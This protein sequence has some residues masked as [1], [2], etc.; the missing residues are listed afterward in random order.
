MTAPRAQRPPAKKTS[1]RSKR[2]KKVPTEPSTWFEQRKL[3]VTNRVQSFLARR[4]HRSFRLTRRRDYR[5]SLTIDGLVPFTYY[6]HKTLWK[7]KAVF[8]WLMAAY[9]VLTALLVTILSQ[10]NYVSLRDTV[11]GATSE[12]SEG[13]WGV[14]GN[15][16]LV[17]FSLFSNAT[18]GAPDT[19]QQ[20]YTI[21]I[22]LMVWLTTVWLLRNI[23]AGNKV[24]VRDGIYNAGAPI[25][26]TFLVLAVL[27]IQLLPLALG[28]IATTVALQT[29]F[30]EY[31]AAAMVMGGVTLLLG[32]LSLYWIT[33]TFMALV[34]VTLP[35]MYPLRALSIAGDM[36]VGRRLRILLRIFWALAVLLAAWFV[37]MVPLI[38]F[39]TWLKD[40]VPAIE[41]IPL[42]PVILVAL[43]AM[44]IVWFASY[45]YLLYRKVVD[46]DA[47][48]A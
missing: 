9:A 39:D 21:L 40:T 8:F 30:F 13:N 25:I 3:A 47:L 43:S 2:T 44:T 1:E 32:L 26:S 36:V 7:H 22:I 46:D 14:V 17:L 23:L 27:I 29:G 28:I 41:W 33:A 34:V 5:R 11:S 35:G 16:A 48:P 19:G 45:V 15:A 37:I 12:I 24:R 4:P 20:V 6:V 42:I 18:T 38:I 31:G 10:D